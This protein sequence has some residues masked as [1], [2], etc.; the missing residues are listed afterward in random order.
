MLDSS[1]ADGDSEVPRW[2]ELR[3]DLDRYLLPRSV[4]RATVRLESGAITELFYLRFDPVA[5]QIR[6]QL[7]ES[8]PLQ[9]HTAYDLVVD[10]LRD[11]DGNLQP[12]EYRIT[13]RTGGAL[14][15]GPAPVDATWSQ[16]APLLE[17]R[18]ALSGCHAPPAAR[19]GLDLSSADAV[20]R[21]A[22][23]ALSSQFP[24]GSLGQAAPGALTLAGLPIVDVVGGGGSPARSYL[25][26]KVLGEDHILGAPM[27]PEGPALAADELRLLADWIQIGA[28]TR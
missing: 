12:E 4:S 6:A 27:P 25:L 2:L 26:Y 28:P 24:S 8:A 11:L 13:F 9:A 21:T 10:E 20:R 22:L 5:Q 18:C 7:P 17:R 1:P 3:V 14:G 23:G 15:D 19:A 16:V